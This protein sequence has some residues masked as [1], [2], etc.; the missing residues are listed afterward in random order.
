LPD[1]VISRGGQPDFPAVAFD[2]RLAFG[3]R[4]QLLAVVGVLLRSGNGNVACLQFER[5]VREDA[6][7]E[8]SPVHF[9]F[10]VPHAED[11]LIPASLADKV[12]I[13]V[14]GRNP[15]GAT[16]LIRFDDGKRIQQSPV[17]SGR[18]ELQRC[19]EPEQQVSVAPVR[20]P[21]QRQVIIVAP[22]LHRFAVFLQPF[23]PAAFGKHL[24]DPLDLGI[25]GI[26]P[27]NR[28]DDPGEGG[29]QIF[30]LL[31]LARLN[32]EQTLARLPMNL[33][34]ALDEHLRGIVPR[35]DSH[36]VDEAQQQCVALGRLHF[37][38]LARV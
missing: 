21:E 23:D 31:P 19:N 11:N 8:L 27:P 13:D 3:P 25:A 2:Q 22:R 37:A 9:A 36:A 15:F 17:L 35:T 28:L 1:E 10:A 24:P 5:Q 38:Q 33:V 12:E 26:I 18:N 34:H 14:F 29:D 20:R 7:L 32:I 30:R 6:D 4:Q 16:I